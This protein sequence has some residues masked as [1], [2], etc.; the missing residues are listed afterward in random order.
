MRANR[1]TLSSKIRRLA[2][3]VL[4]LLR[5]LVAASVPAS[6]LAQAP[7]PGSDGATGFDPTAMQPFTRG[8]LYLGKHETGLY[9]GGKNELPLAHRQAGERIAASIRPLDRIGPP[10]DQSGRILALVFG[11]SNCRIYCD[12]LQRH[13]ASHATELHPRFEMLNA[14]MGGQQLPQ[15]V[16]PQGPVWDTANQLASRPG[17]STQQVRV[18]SCTPL[19]TAGKT[20]VVNRPASSRRRCSKCSTTR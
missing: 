15:I 20:S 12:A 3:A 1:R 17:Y 5:V 16:R 6:A 8:T 10:D 4:R 7:N 11:H 19:I 9:P 2:Q 14:A 18:C 13:L